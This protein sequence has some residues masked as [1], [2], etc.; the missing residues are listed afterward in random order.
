MGGWGGPEKDRVLRHCLVHGLAIIH[1]L[2]Q[3]LLR[4]TFPGLGSGL[5]G[6][7]M[8]FMVRD[9]N[10]VWGVIPSWHFMNLL[11]FL[12]ALQVH[13]HGTSGSSV[14]SKE[15]WLGSTS[16]RLLTPAGSV[17]RFSSIHWP[18][19]AGPSCFSAAPF[20]LGILSAAYT[21]LPLSG[22]CTLDRT[23]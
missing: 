9:P 8:V 14:L 1:H 7:G 6:C 11:T 2:V 4:G 10:L 19:L 23:E 16:C 20:S 21:V 15:S 5:I 13:A 22:H 12:L 3:V 17:V 18:F